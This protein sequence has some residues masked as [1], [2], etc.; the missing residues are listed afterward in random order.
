[1]IALPEIVVLRV[2]GA[3]GARTCVNEGF[4]S[5]ETIAA[6][7]FP[8]R[9]VVAEG[10]DLFTLAAAAVGRVLPAGDAW[11][12]TIGAVVAVTFSNPDRFPSLA[13]RVAAL[14]GLPPQT[15]AFDLQAACSAYPQALYQAGRLAADLGRRVL[16]VHGDVQ[17]RLADAGDAA[18]APL[19]SDAA[20]ATVLE[21]SAA[22]VSRFSFLSRASTAL[23]CAAG[24]PI[25]MDGFKV[26]QFVATDVVRFLRTFDEAVDSFVP[27]QANMY[28]VR[29]LAKSLGHADRLVT[30]GADLANPGGCSVPLALARAGRPGRALLAGF[31]AGLAASA[32]VVRLAETVA[33]GVYREGEKIT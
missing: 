7:G 12:E 5:P 31:G 19:F 9:C 30:C 23:R 20:T 26:F 11:R 24:G 16:V 27:H 32:G 18:T 14:L 2:A 29:Q 28:M 10:E 25:E 3:V 8:T 6:T 17:S 22:G 13:V 33:C 1:M 15:P 21:A 4:A